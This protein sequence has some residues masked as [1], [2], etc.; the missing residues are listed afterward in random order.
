M[1]P[2]RAEEVVGAALG[3]EETADTLVKQLFCQPVC[4]G[5]GGEVGHPLLESRRLVTAA[6]L[7]VFATLLKQVLGGG[8]E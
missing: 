2:G 3:A 1:G 5:E 8:R 7:L 6:V 4:S